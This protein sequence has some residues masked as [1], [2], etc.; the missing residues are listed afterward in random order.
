MKKTIAFI[1]WWLNRLEYLFIWIYQRPFLV[2]LIENDYDLIQFGAYLVKPYLE[3]ILQQ[4]VL[5]CI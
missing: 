2:W 5:Y 1:V 3:Y 4:K